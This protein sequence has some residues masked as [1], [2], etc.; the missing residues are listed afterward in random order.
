MFCMGQE[1]HAA[2]IL[3][4]YFAGTL[5][6]LHLDGLSAYGHRRL[7]AS[8]GVDLDRLRGENAPVG[9]HHPN[10]VVEAHLRNQASF[11][12]AVIKLDSA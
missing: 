6:A 5:P 2:K 12:G 3:K 8:Q 4:V 9:G 10:R 7:A 1:S 11:I